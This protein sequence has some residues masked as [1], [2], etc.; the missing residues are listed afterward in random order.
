MAPI[1]P[2]IRFAI[3]ISIAFIS[4]KALAG[5]SISWEEVLYQISQDDPDFANF[6]CKQF[7]I[8]PVGGAM[9]VGHDRKG[10]PT[11]PGMQVGNR[12]PPYTFY[13]NPRYAEGEYQLLLTLEPED[14]NKRKMWHVTVRMKRSSD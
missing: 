7:S 8:A 3:C 1:K 4:P 6:L 9:R 10:D 13:A 11:V 14:S 5:G 2:L 12:L